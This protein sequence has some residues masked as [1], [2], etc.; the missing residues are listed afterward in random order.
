MVDSKRICFGLALT[1]A[2]VPALPG[3][4]ATGIVGAH[5]DEDWHNDRQ[6]PYFGSGWLESQGG[7]PPVEFPSSG[8]TLR[9]WI[10]VV[11][12]DAAATAANDCWGYVSPSGREYALIGLSLGTGFVEVTD[13]AN[14][15]IVAVLAGPPSSWRDIKT[16]RSYAYAASEGGAGIQVFDLGQIDAG[17]V[18]LV[19]TVTAG[20]RVSTHNLAVNTESGMLYRV[21]GG[22]NPVRGLRIY[23]L[24]DPSLPAFVGEWNERYCHDAQGVT[25][26]GAPY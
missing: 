9:S 17:V 7:S 3:H 20:G 13:P 24:A 2:C 19:D 8:V 1:L 11:D 18:S 12:F 21:G 25:W 15:Q 6:P 23:S 4:A 10:P 16:Y 14:A 5:D 26:S 22:G